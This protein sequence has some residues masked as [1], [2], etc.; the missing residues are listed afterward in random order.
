MHSQFIEMCKQVNWLVSMATSHSQSNLHPQIQYHHGKLYLGERQSRAAK[1]QVNTFPHGC[2]LTCAW[3]GLWSLPTSLNRAGNKTE[4]V[5]CALITFSTFS[6][7]CGMTFRLVGSLGQLAD[8]EGCYREEVNLALAQPFEFPLFPKH[9]LCSLPGEPIL[10]FPSPATP[11]NEV[12]FSSIT[13]HLD[14]PLKG[15]ESPSRACTSGRSVVS[16]FVHHY[17]GVFLCSTRPTWLHLRSCILMS[18]SWMV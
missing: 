10:L 16:V 13:V 9:C 8:S 3:R 5:T 6:P 17:Y 14:M 18:P 2:S 4:H 7:W 15:R 1:G 11:A 12:C